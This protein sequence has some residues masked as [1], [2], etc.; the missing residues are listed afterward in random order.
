MNTNVNTHPSTPHCVILGVTGSIAA[1]KAADLTSGLRKAGVDTHVVLTH[2]AMK[3]IQPKTF[4]TLSRNPV[5]TDLWDVPGWQ[6]EHISLA[7]RADILVVAPATA[8]FIGKYANGIADDALSTFAL[9]HTGPVILAPAMN[10]RMWGHT[11]VQENCMKLRERGAIFVGPGSGFVACGDEGEGRLAEVEDILHEIRVQLVSNSL[12]AR[13][14]ELKRIVVTAG[15]TCEDI[16]PVRFLTNRSSGKMGYAIAEV[17]A[18]CGHDVVLIT[19]PT[20]LERPSFC[21]CI[22]VR[23][24]SEM[25]EAVKKEFH[26]ADMLIM[27]A[28]VADYSPKKCADQKIHKHDGSMKLELQRTDDILAGISEVKQS[29]QTVVGFAAET[30]NLSDSAESKLKRKKLNW[31]VANDISRKDI[32]FGANDNEVIVYSA[33]GR[34]ATFP[35]MSK[36]EL[37]GKLLNLFIH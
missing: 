3:L 9:S 13:K 12:R 23:S 27:S 8:N 2:S 32:G 29:G 33:E 34:I 24:A 17:A 11:A 28:A 4:Q 18:S 16:D 25:N 7:D 22:S 37:A 6:P 14:K 21:R 36:Y 20:C 30:E 26:S 1:Y 10:P 5:I 35:R 19:G 31:I 15:P